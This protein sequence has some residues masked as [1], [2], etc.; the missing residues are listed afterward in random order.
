MTDTQ[1][2]APG[3]GAPGAVLNGWSPDPDSPAATSGPRVPGH[4]SIAPRVLQKVG[5]AVVSDALAVDRHDVHVDARD[6]DGRLALRVST[7][8]SVPAL[9][10][11]V[12]VPDGGVLGTIRTLQQTVTGRILTITGRAVSRVDVTV[13]ASRSPKTTTGRVR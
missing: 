10:A 6:D 2:A 8:V 13:T 4:I 5:S 1:T 12:V 3:N 11:D 9:S 7:P